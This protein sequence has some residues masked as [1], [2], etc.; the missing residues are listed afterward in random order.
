[1]TQ[2]YG[3]GGFISIIFVWFCIP[4]TKDR[5]LEEISFM[6]SA[7][8]PIRKWKEYDLATV[9]AKDDKKASR[10]SGV[11]EHVEKGNAE[12]VPGGGKV[13]RF[14]SLDSNRSTMVGP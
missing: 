1:M 7:R 10:F 5:T 9:V 14:P 11:S 2:I 8:I 4:E 12:E 6:F 3:F 13:R